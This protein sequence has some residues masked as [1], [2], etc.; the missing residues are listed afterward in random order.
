MVIGLA[1]E[2]TGIVVT[3]RGAVVT[4]GDTV[5]SFSPGRYAPLDKLFETAKNCDQ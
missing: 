1:V 4:E 2:V 3:G 5:S